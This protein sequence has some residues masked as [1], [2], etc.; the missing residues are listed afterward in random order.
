MPYPLFDYYLVLDLEATCCDRKL[1]PYVK[2]EII[3]IGA[4]MINSMF[5]SVSEFQRFVK[6]SFNPDLTPFCTE[7]TSITQEMVDVAPSYDVA[8]GEFSQW[9]A[10]YPGFVFCAWGDFDR[11]QI[12]Y[13]CKRHGLPNPIQTTCLN[14]RTMF[15]RSQEL[16]GL[17]NLGESMK[18]ANLELTGVQHRGIDDAR[19]IAKLLP[20]C[21]GHR[22]IDR[23][24]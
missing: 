11:R 21:L 18:M 22:R 2:R 13:E 15:D 10:A 5:Q 3:E 14:L 17:F 16:P 12:R 24:S 9:I 19:N 6:P 8:I 1:R 23:R 20:F 7:L 4:V